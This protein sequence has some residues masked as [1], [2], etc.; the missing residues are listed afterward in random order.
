MATYML[1]STLTDDGAKTI[2]KNPG[3]IKEV[4]AEVEKMGVKIKAQYALLGP[5]D[6]LTIVEA[7]DNETV[8]R[9]SAHLGARGTIKI[10]TLPAIPVDAL[11]AR[12]K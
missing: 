1:L 5:Y 12:L 11:I 3:R 4:S 9:L 7:E 8:A 2:T 6:F 10:T